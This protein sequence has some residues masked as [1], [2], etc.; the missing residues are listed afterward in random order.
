[1]QTQQ[2]KYWYIK[3]STIFNELDEKDYNELDWISCM[4]Q[5]KKHDF[6]YL[7]DETSRK[8]YY[9]KQGL[10]KLGYYDDN[11]NEVILDIL[12]PG[13]F[14]GEI[15]FGKPI[16]QQ[17]FA[18]SIANDTK[19][20]N[21]NII[22]LEKLFERKPQLALRFTKKV[23]NQQMMLSRRLSKIIYKD[24]RSR[25]IDFFKDWIDELQISETK[26]ITFKNYLTHQDIASLN[27]LARQTV[28]TILSE[29]KDEELIIF[30]RAT[31]KIPNVYNL[32]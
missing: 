30:E 4:V 10:V 31:I 5:C 7:P 19:M 24:S 26:D 2:T 3:N 23:G 25:L 17:E 13:D 16:N 32:K 27:G 21:F 1:M 14:F 18:Q 9:L 15:G 28:S 11:G 29:F 6:V 8:V 22:E 12:K 20:C